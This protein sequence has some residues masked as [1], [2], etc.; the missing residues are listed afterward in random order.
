MRPTQTRRRGKCA[1]GGHGNSHITEGGSGNSSKMK[2]RSQRKSA[3]SRRPSGEPR[4]KRVKLEKNVKV[5]AR[6]CDGGEGSGGVCFRL[7][8][9]Q[10]TDSCTDQDLDD[11]LSSH[12]RLRRLSGGYNGKDHFSKL[13]LEILCHIMSY[14]P[15][16]DTIKLACL[17]GTLREAVN[18]HIRLLTRVDLTENHIYGWMPTRFTD[19][20]FMKLLKR[21]P[22]VTHIYGLNPHVISKRRQRG[23][24]VLSIPGVIAALSACPRLKGIETCDIFVLEA[25]LTYLPKKE[26]LRTFQNRN[27]RFPIPLSN[28]FGLTRNPRVTSLILSGV[29]L[30][31]LPRMDHLKHLHLRWVKLTD[32]HPFK[33]FG[34]PQ[35]R[36][37][38]MSNCDGP[39]NALKYVPLITGLAAARSL[40]RLELIR[41]PFLGKMFKP[42]LSYFYVHQQPIKL[43]SYQSVPVATNPKPMSSKYSFGL[44]KNY[45]IQ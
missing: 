14:L 22:D 18:M 16:T 45:Q 7:L 9:V 12:P 33:D 44:V 43:M 5:K 31:E 40:M 24:D 17:C 28:K 4:T 39:S 42:K 29:V 34:V 2:T 10:K 3:Q 8:T 36:T 6:E 27:G 25:I 35:L 20:T 23:Q 26:I 37:F 19:E 1:G 11:F 30:P 13:S 41:V 15:L 38:V 21:C 32:P